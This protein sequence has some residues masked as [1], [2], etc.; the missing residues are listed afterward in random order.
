MQRHDVIIVGA[1]PAGSTCAWRLREKHVDV[2]LLDKC[3]FPRD[4]PCAGWITP[5]VLS[6]LE[7]NPAE[8]AAGRTL[9]PITGFAVSQLG[10]PVIDNDYGQVVS[11]GI[12]RCE[13]DHYLLLRSG[14]SCR[15]GESV[16]RIEK[17]G[18]TW[19]INDRYEAPVIVGAGGH[20]C[21]V[22]RFLGA[23]AAGPNPVVTAQEI[24]F[25]L[26]EPQREHC[27]VRPHLP[28]LYFCDDLRGY[29]WCV[30]KQ[31][32]L[33]IGLGREDR[34]SLSRHVRQFVESLQRTGHVPDDLPGQF[35]G[36][37]YALYAHSHRPLICDGMLTIGDA[38]GLAATHSGEGIRAAVESGRCAAEVILAAAGRY[39]REFLMAYERRI[40]SRFGPRKA[41]DSWI[42]FIPP[43]LKRAV[44]GRLM[45]TAWFTRHVVLDRW[46]LA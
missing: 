21:P 35:R 31:N 20:F 27:S 32:H 12:R 16:T 15:Q 39:D 7:I 30:R 17:C 40:V 1:G 41:A 3:E 45:A 25:A 24:E 46:F 5:P 22:A 10:G 23:K 43:Q 26:T 44:A 37:A 38:A 42:R 36:H 28:E 8:Y 6:L 29:G 34:D 4:K 9:Q 19:R 13:F 11:Y 14:A 2:L 18:G 33:N